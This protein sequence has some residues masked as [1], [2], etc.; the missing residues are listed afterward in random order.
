MRS[1]HMRTEAFAEQDMLITGG[2]GNRL[3][4]L[5]AFGPTSLSSGWAIH[6]ERR[7]LGL[8]HGHHVDAIH[9]LKPGSLPEIRQS[10]E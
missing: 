4:G 8:S 6:E 9:Y 5:Y 2:R 7:T 10:F 1:T 3:I